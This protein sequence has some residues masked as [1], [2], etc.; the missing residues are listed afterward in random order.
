QTLMQAASTPSSA[1]AQ[2]PQWLFEIPF[3]VPP[4]AAI[5]QFEIGRDEEDPAAP[6]SDEAEP[7][8]R[9]RFSLDLDPMGPVH[10][11]I[12]LRGGRIRVSLW[13]ERGA[14]A[15]QLAAQ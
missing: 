14:T 2:T 12:S 6:A 10:A 9:A 7:T 15:A 3:V 4:G 5:A 13:A 8:W 11:R 1:A